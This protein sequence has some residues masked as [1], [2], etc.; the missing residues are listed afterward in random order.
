ML[1]V[2]NGYLLATIANR[3][4]ERIFGDAPASCAGVHPGADRDRVRV[5]ADGNVVLKA[6]VE[7]LEVLAY[8]HHVYVFIAPSTHKG[9]GTTYISVQLKF[10]T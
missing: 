4:L 6:D 9:A 5:V 8:Q 10:F 2:H 3:I 7:T 1:A